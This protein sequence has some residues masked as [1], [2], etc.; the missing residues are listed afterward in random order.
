MLSRT[1]LVP[2]C[3]QLWARGQARTRKRRA[4][5]RPLGRWAVNLIWNQER[6]S[7]ACV[8]DAGERGPCHAKA[9][10]TRCSGAHPG[11]ARRGPLPWP[12]VVRDSASR[13]FSDDR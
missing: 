10:G 5:R 6:H 13:E 1:V 4:A 3:S 8:A 2:S 12:R 7:I 11:L 9:P